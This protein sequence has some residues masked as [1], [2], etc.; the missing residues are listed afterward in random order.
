M[1]ASMFE[2]ILV[3]HGGPSP[4]MFHNVGPRCTTIRYRRQAGKV[5]P[6]RAGPPQDVADLHRRPCAAAGGPDPASR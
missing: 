4:E 5:Q 6:L 2:G 1:T 3:A